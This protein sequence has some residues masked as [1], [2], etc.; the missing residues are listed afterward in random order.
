LNA[1]V[2]APINILNVDRPVEKYAVE[3][4]NERETEQEKMLL[5]D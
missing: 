2:R 1:V 4:G 5:P 3:N